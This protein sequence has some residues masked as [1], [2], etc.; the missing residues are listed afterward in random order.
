MKWHVPMALGLGAL[1]TVVFTAS[2]KAAYESGAEFV[3]RFLLWPNTLLQSLIPCLNIGTPEEP[4]CEG[5]PL[6]LLAFGAS[7]LLS[8]AV[9]ASIAYVLIRRHNLMRA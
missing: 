2:A 5:T 8:V 1:L 9:Y 4:F 3:A 6:H 7:E